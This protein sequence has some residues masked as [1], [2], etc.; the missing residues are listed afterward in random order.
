MIEHADQAWGAYT[1]LAEAQ[2]FKVKTIGLQVGQR[3]SYQGHSRRSEHWFVV[4]G[5]G[6]V[7]LDR[8]SIDVRRGDP[9][10]VPVGTAHRIRN[11]GNVPL[12]FVEVQHGV[13]FGE[14]DIVPWKMTTDACRWREHRE[15]KAGLPT[16]L[17]QSRVISVRPPGGSI[18]KLAREAYNFIGRVKDVTYLPKP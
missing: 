3:L 16:A 11:T 13:Y 12:V 8:N 4:G 5:E 18:G 10:D 6:V 15:L 7:T 1:V 14:D 2:D 17:F 9:V